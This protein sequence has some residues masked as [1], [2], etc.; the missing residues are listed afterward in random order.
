[1]DVLVVVALAVA[2]VFCALPGIMA[3]SFYFGGK[4]QLEVTNLNLPGGVD[5][6]GTWM[7]VQAGPVLRYFGSEDL[8]PFLSVFV[9]RVWGTYTV[10]ETI[11]D[12]TGTEEKKIS[13]KGFIRGSFGI[14][15]A[16]SAYF[17]LEAEVSALPYNKVLGGLDF[18]YGASVVGIFSF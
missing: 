18:D 10:N 4:K 13:G 8:S 1:M 12:L 11:F 6:R 5:A 17:S 14:T 15:Y 16:P 3:W 2:V 7:R 9:D